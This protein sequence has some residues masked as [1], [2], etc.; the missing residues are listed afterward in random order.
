MDKFKY[1][2][3]A[4]TNQNYIQ[5]ELKSRLNSG[6]LSIIQLRFFPQLPSNVKIM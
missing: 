6:M 2:E 1:L 5:E 4:V 3:T